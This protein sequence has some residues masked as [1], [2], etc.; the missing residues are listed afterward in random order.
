MTLLNPAYAS[1]IH[2]EK[3]GIVIDDWFMI[4]HSLWEIGCFKFLKLQPVRRTGKY[5]LFSVP[6][7]K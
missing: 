1:D 2:H 5:C 3:E 7:A 4:L 6:E